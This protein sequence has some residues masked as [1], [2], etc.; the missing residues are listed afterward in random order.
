MDIRRS[1]R[2]LHTLAAMPRRHARPRVLLRKRLVKPR[3]FTRIRSESRRHQRRIRH[4]V[5]GRVRDWKAR[6]TLRE[7]AFDLFRVFHRA[8]DGDSEAAAVQAVAGAF[9]NFL[10]GDGLDAVLDFG[11]VEDVAVAEEAFAHP[12]HLIGGAFE[13]HQGLPDGV[14]LRLPEFFLARLFAA[15]GFEFAEDEADG[16]FEVFRVESGVEGKCSGVFEGH[17]AGLHAVAVAA[18][19]AEFLEKARAHVFAEDDAEELER[20]AAFVAASESVEAHGEVRLLGVLRDE[21]NAGRAFAKARATEARGA[22]GRDA[23]QDA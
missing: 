5:H 1:R 3:V 19:F 18:F 9:L 16:A 4:A 2:A 15:D 7:P 11:G 8:D 13:A 23:M 12:H 10:G 22:T 6:V 14:V 21:R 20:E 17:G